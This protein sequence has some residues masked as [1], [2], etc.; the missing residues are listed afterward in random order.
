M[1]NFKKAG[2]AAFISSALMAASVNAFA[3]DTI[4][5][6][7]DG[8]IVETTCTIDQKTDGVAIDLGKVLVADFPGVGEAGASKDVSLD[9]TGCADGIKPVVSAQGEVN[10]DNDQAY[11]NTADATGVG[12]QL[13]SDATVLDAA[14]LNT[15]PVTIASGEGS[16]PLTAS[17]IQTTAT[18]PSTGHVNSVVTLN[19]VYN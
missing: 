14:G 2:V 17:M 7:V 6:T 10:P 18:A 13:K 4:Q 3:A 9:F 16:M 8:D 12:V 11:K 5:V 15:V 19:V 1:F